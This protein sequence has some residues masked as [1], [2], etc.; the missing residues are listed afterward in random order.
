MLDKTP[1][2]YMI[3]LTLNR[4]NRS[5]GSPSD[6]MHRGLEDDSIIMRTHAVR[7][8]MHARREN[9]TQSLFMGLAHALNGRIKQ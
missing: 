9:T 6:S 5:G 1:K 3:A 2:A 4:C 7:K 8:T